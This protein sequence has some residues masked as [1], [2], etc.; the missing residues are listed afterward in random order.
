MLSFSTS[1]LRN[2]LKV[3]CE[4]N[5][6]IILEYDFVNPGKGQA[7]NRV[8][9]RNLRNGKILKKTFK[10]GERIKAANILDVKADYSYFDGNYHI[11]MDNE[12]FEQYIVSNIVL[13]DTKKW[14]KPQDN[15]LLTLFNSQVIAVVAPNLVEL[16]VADTDPG[17]K[18]DTAGTASKMATL[19]TGAIVRVPLFVQPGEIIKI[20]TR[21]NEYISR[22]KG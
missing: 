6:M 9:L 2:G 14:I 16:Q 8:K 10:I 15:C 20:N 18:G 7:F 11:F 17:F 22:V 5:P 12:T 19:E 13:R 3:L 1:E 21:N 4:G